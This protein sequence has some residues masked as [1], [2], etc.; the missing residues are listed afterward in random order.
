MPGPLEGSTPSGEETVQ[1]ESFFM[2]EVSLWSNGAPVQL[3][4][5]T[6]ATLEFLLPK[7]LASQFQEGDTVPGVV[8]RL[9]GG[10]LAPGGNGT[11]QP[12]STQPGRLAWVVQVSHFTW[13]NCDAPV[14]GQEL[15]QRP[16]R[17]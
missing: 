13:W 17:G 11:I 12:S 2:A 8:V 1:L 5:G 7:A 10:P 9:G 14:D 15:R 4:P 6:K 16:C 3:A